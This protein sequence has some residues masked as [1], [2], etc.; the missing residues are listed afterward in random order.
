MEYDYDYECEPEDLTD[1]FKM[2]Y[3]SETITGKQLKE[4]DADD[5]EKFLLDKYEEA[6]SEEAEENYEPESGSR[7]PDDYEYYYRYSAESL[8]DTSKGISI[9]EALNM[10]S[11]TE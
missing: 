9:Q 1:Y 2:T 8:N 7:D 11:K 4:F 6:A 10:L 5:F 3:G